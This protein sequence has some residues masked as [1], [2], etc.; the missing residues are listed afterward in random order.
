MMHFLNETGVRLHCHCIPWTMPEQETHLA[1]THT[2]KADL[3]AFFHTFTD[4]DFISDTAL[5]S[6]FY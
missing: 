1:P 4:F 6:P 3:A 5:A 2:E